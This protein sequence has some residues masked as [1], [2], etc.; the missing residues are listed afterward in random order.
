MD[1]DLMEL[2]AR[3]KKG[4]AYMGSPDIA[5]VEKLKHLDRF[6]ELTKQLGEATKDMDIEILRGLLK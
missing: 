5:N 4:E 2:I 3:Y 1:F 6:V